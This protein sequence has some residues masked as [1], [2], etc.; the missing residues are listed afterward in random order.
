VLVVVMPYSADVADDGNR[1]LVRVSGEIDFETGP[2]LRECIGGAAGKRLPVDV[3]LSAVRVMDSFGLGC[4]IRASRDV[5]MLGST[6]T[7]VRASPAVEQLFRVT[8]TADLFGT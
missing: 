6:L 4:L 2:R 3:D 7:V 5:R 8:G 1:C